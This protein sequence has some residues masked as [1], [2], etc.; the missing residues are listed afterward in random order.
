[1][2]TIKKPGA[3]TADTIGQVGQHYINLVNGD[4]YECVKID[5]KR[6][7]EKD[8]VNA[9]SFFSQKVLAG[10]DG[11]YIWNLVKAGG[12]GGASSWNDLTDRP[13]YEETEIVNEPL[14]ITW[15]G[16]TEGLLCVEEPD[17]TM[18]CKVSNIILTDEHI[19]MIAETDSVGYTENVGEIW[20]ELVEQGQVSEDFVAA[21]AT[22]VRKDGAEVLGIVFPEAGIYFR[23]WFNGDHLTSITTTEPIEYTKT[24][25]HTLDKKFLP[26][27]EIS[28]IVFTGVRNDEGWY[29]RTCNVD[30][31]KA[32]TALIDGAT[33]RMILVDGNEIK[34]LTL[35]FVK[36]SNQ[37][38]TLNFFDITDIGNLDGVIRYS[39]DGSI[40]SGLE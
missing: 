19:K 12:S 23:M 27:A 1:M 18:L 17:G 3:P 24:T 31:A 36:Y 22:Y 10:A 15:D 26:K 25:V 7:Y 32:R 2:I 38:V 9:N 8:S 40:G 33:A 34:H 5:D 39:E 29:D 28:D 21:M 16:N 4:E 30:Y 20:D 14:N 6:V 13:F 37:S 35:Q 11:H